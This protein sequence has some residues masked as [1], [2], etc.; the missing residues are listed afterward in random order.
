MLQPTYKITNTFSR[1]T[2]FIRFIITNTE[3]EMCTTHYIYSRCHN[4]IVTY[5][6]YLSIKL[7]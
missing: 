3:I 2:D 4:Y 6:I 7:C 5:I 1:R